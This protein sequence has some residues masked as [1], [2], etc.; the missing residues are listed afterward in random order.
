MLHFGHSCDDDAVIEVAFCN[1]WIIRVTDFTWWIIGPASLV[2]LLTYSDMER[3]LLGSKPWF[4]SVVWFYQRNSNFDCKFL[5][6]QRY[7]A[8]KLIKVFP[9]I[10]WDCGD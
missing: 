8:K 6:F 1:A 10:G 5:H 4:V 9:N 7:G 2:N 3:V